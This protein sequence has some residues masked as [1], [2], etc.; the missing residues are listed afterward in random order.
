MK[1]QTSYHFWNLRKVSLFYSYFAYVDMEEYY[2]DSL[3]IKHEVKVRFMR[4]YLNPD[5]PYI[6][7]FC[8]VRKRDSQRF[9]DALA[10]LPNKMLLCGH[11]DYQSFCIELSK[12]MKSEIKTRREGA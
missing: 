3:F 8:K 10:Q 6:V 1:E 4:E 2:A 7:I 12:K 11:L 5:S 9:L